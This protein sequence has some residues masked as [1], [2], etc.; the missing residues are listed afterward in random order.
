MCSY[1]ELDALALVM[2]R[3]RNK[4]IFRKILKYLFSSET[5]QSH[6]H[7]RSHCV[8]AHLSVFKDRANVREEWEKCALCC[9]GG[10]TR[11][12][13]WYFG[14]KVMLWY[15]CIEIIWRNN[16]LYTLFCQLEVPKVT[17]RYQSL[18]VI[19]TSFIFETLFEHVTIQSF[20][21]L[22]LFQQISENNIWTITQCHLIQR[23]RWSL[24]AAVPDSL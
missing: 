13:E 12:M 4:K 22:V 2:N 21:A 10:Q 14:T 7:R 11:G 17:P 8:S 23:G 6:P 16:D 24:R 3:D 18:I 1:L 20:L 19:N 9:M 5:D 15:I